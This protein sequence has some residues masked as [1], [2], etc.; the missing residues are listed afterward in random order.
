MTVNVWQHFDISGVTYKV[1]SLGLLEIS[2]MASTFYQKKLRAD[3]KEEADD[4]FGDSP[5]DRVEFINTQRDKWPKGEDL[6]NA[7]IMY[8][9]TGECQDLFCAY[10]LNRF[11]R[12]LLPDMD[13]A[14]ELLEDMVLEDQV[15]MFKAIFGT[16][17]DIIE[18]SIEEGAKEVEEPGK[19]ETETEKETEPK[20]D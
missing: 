12:K 7:A 19:E 8:A 17:T 2:S 4:F 16:M 10:A 3:L 5:R 20:E 18:T 15:E 1:K 9:E 6:Q 11:N 13:K 14:L